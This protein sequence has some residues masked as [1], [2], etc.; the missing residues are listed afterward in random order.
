M[1]NTAA[2]EDLHIS[3]VSALC[4]SLDISYDT[5]RHDSDSTDGIIKKRIILDNGTM[6]DA[7]LRIQLKCTASKSLYSDDGEFITYKL[8]SKN[9]N[10]LCTAATTPIILGLLI[11]PDSVDKCVCWTPEEL[12]IKGC[13][14]WKS[15]SAENTTGNSD[16]V[17]VKIDKRNVLNKENL[18]I[19]LEQIAK[20]EWT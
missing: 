10:D 15:F 19:I 9:F 2:M 17:S 13:M 18:Q 8:K 4:A 20:E 5:L 11:L 16:T 14:Y 12:V 1:S 7:S 3:Y 6:F